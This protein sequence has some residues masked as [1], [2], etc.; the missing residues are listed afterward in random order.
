[1]PVQPPKETPKKSIDIVCPVFREEE[2]IGAFHSQLSTALEPL[3]ERY[4]LKIIYVVD[5]SHDRTET[6]LADISAKDARVQVLVMSR[7]FG[8][9][10]ALVAGLDQSDGDALVML[11][12]DL[13]H[14]PELIPEM[15]RFWEQG[16][17]IVQTLRQDGR[18]TRFFKRVSSRLFYELLMKIGSVDLGNGAA[19]FRLMS[20]RVVRVFTDRLREHNPFLRGL[21]GWVGFNIVYLPYQPAKREHGTTKYRISTLFNF[22]INGIFSFSNVPLRFCTVMGIVIA[23]FSM[24]SMLAQVGAYILSVR[25]VPGWAS[26]FTATSLIGG[27]QLIFL[28]ILGEY[29][30]LIFDEVK[31]RPRYLV[32]R[33]IENGRT[34]RPFADDRARKTMDHV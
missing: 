13:Q 10:A 8:Q 3:G 15:I 18:E 20:K 4:Q 9:Q 34:E 1:M 33:H 32:D 21:I 19:D 6:I 12:S 31:N 30:S 11:D 29:V 16:A 28:G 22:A 24:I 27:I 5:P 26:E 2:V 17:E 14:P 7:R 23:A 25:S